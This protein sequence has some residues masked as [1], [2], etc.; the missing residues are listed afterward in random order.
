MPSGLTVA[1]AG[2]LLLHT[3][4]GLVAFAGFTSAVNGAPFPAT[5]VNEG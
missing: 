3:T 4:L 2:L 5:N 1:T